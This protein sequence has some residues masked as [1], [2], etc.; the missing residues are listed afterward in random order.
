MRGGNI[1]KTMSTT[2]QHPLYA[3][4]RHGSHAWAFECA[5]G[6]LEGFDSLADATKAADKQKREDEAECRDASKNGM[7]TWAMRETL[8]LYPPGMSEPDSPY[9]ETPSETAVA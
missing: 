8:N 5:I 2:F 4:Y 9:S 7:L 6:R 1:S 3:P